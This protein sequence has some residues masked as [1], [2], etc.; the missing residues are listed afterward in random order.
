MTAFR[1]EFPSTDVFT[2]LLMKHASG[3]LNAT[4]LYNA[5]W[6]LAV[7]LG[8]N[9]HDEMMDDYAKLP[10][11]VSAGKYEQDDGETTENCKY[12]ASFVCLE[13]AIAA[14]EKCRSYP[15]SRIT[16][17]SGDFCY[18]IEP[19]RVSR[20]RTFPDGKSFYMPCDF[21]GTFYNEDA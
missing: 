10:F 12:V 19:T 1:T 3:E 14:K 9:S 13:D 11:D 15:W 8:L 7:E 2:A 16:L 5:Q 20:K 6:K 4:E 17:C 18:E 21:D